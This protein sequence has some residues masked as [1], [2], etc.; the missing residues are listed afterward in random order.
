MLIEI[1]DTDISGIKVEIDD[2]GNEYYISPVYCGKRISPFRA[3]IGYKFEFYNLLSEELFNASINTDNNG[4]YGLVHTAVYLPNS[5][6]KGLQEAY[7]G[8]SI[9]DRRLYDHYTWAFVEN[10][11]GWIK[12]QIEKKLKRNQLFTESIYQSLLEILS[13][14]WQQHIIRKED[15]EF[16]HF[17]FAAERKLYAKSSLRAKIHGV[18]GSGKTMYAVQRAIVRYRN[19]KEPVVILC[20]NLTLVNYLVDRI[21]SMSPDLNDYDRLFGIRVETYDRFMPQMMKINGFDP[22]YITYDESKDEQE[23]I[24]EENKQKWRDLHHSQIE[25]FESNAEKMDFRKYS[26]IIIDE[27]QDYAPEWL[28]AIDRY[29]CK[30]GGELLILADEK[31]QLYENAEMKDMSLVTPGIDGD[32]LLLTEPHRMTNELTDVAL[33]FQQEILKQFK[34]DEVHYVELDFIHEKSKLEYYNNNLGP[35][36]IVRLIRL[37]IEKTGVGYSNTTVLSGSK[38]VLQSIDEYIR[39]YETGIE[40]IT[41]FESMETRREIGMHFVQGSKGYQ[42]KINDAARIRKFHFHVETE[43]LKL[44]TIQ[45]FKGLETEAV[46]YILNQNEDDN[47]RVYTAITRARTH[48][49]VINLGNQKYDAFF[50]NPTHRFDKIVPPDELFSAPEVLQVYDEEELPF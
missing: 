31:Q 35:G 37:F 45:S 38:N 14:S 13:G 3:V 8:N 29:F 4:N 34:R 44:S 43:K 10:T 16:K 22:L 12:Q 30:K 6:L 20:Y 27:Y 42:R 11:D 2:N 32:W 46:V 7:K 26:T 41:T 39:E 40:T 33:A 24:E 48:L 36:Q 9:L 5:S 47:S 49:L 17:Q 50:A 28:Y 23:Y 25:V 18:A 15:T 19:T 1:Y 21:I